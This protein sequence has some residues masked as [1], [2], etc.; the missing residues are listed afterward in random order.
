MSLI[1]QM[2]SRGDIGIIACNSGMPFAE[3]IMAGLERQHDKLHPSSGYL[4]RPNIH[5]TLNKLERRVSGRRIP[6][7]GLNLRKNLISLVKEELFPRRGFSLIKSEEMQFP[8]GE[9][10]AEILESIRGKDIYVVQDTENKVTKYAIDK[11]VIAMRHAMDAAWRAGAGSIT[12]VF[13]YFAY[14]RQEVAR[15]RECIA[16]ARMIRDLEASHADHILTLDI[17]NPAIAGVCSTTRFED[18][19]AS[20]NHLDYIRSNIPLDNLVVCSPDTGAVNRNRYFANRLQTDLAMIWKRRDYSGGGDV[21]EMMFLGD[22]RGKDVLFV[23][24]MIAT[25]GTL[26]KACKLVK[27]NG[28]RDVYFVTSLPLF[29][30]PAISRID[31][32]YRKGHIKQIIGTDAVFHG[33]EDFSR[34]H[35]WYSEVSVAGYFAKVIWN[36]NHDCSISDLLSDRTDGFTYDKQSA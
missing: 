28:A 11:N 14:S 18:L 2:G 13:P 22:V 26:V 8:N 5:E 34:K 6:H 33:G 24:D 17:H 27:D 16:A 12:A 9:I 3:G 32:A 1:K 10:K 4:Q 21:A 19:R 15:G 30:D 7:S 31:E 23:D 29:T 20:K 36:L 25:A 35:P